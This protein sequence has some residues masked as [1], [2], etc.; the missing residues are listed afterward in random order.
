MYML[1]IE[2]NNIAR[3]A[4]SRATATAGEGDSGDAASRPH[5]LLRTP[6]RIVN[7]NVNYSYI[8]FIKPRYF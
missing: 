6:P 7:T 8:S 3:G 4:R 2:P 5:S 1:G